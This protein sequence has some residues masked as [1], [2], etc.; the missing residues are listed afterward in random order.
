VLAT[1][2]VSVREILEE[3]KGLLRD[4]YDASLLLEFQRVQALL[5]TQRIKI[6]QNGALVIEPDRLPSLREARQTVER[7]LVT[8]AMK[9]AGGNQP[10]AAKILGISKQR[11]NWLLKNQ[12]KRKK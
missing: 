4:Y 1:N 9:Q 10:A 12:P 5:D 6:T 2:A 7:W 3:T 8:N 11:I